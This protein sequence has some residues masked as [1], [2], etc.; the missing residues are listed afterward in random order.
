MRLY[1]STHIQYYVMFNTYGCGV[2][3]YGV[4][5]LWCYS[6]IMILWYSVTMSL[7]SHSTGF[8]VKCNGRLIIPMRMSRGVPLHGPS[9][10]RTLVIHSYVVRNI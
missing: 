4:V 3:W 8:I 1:I 2:A 9:N 5:L 10:G 7:A 6:V